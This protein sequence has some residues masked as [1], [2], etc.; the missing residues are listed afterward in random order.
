MSATYLWLVIIGMH[1]VCHRSK[2]ELSGIDDLFNIPVG[3]ST[4]LLL[5]MSLVGQL[6]IL[7][8]YPSH[9]EPLLEE[10]TTPEQVVTGWVSHIG[11]VGEEL[12]CCYS[13]VGVD[14][15]SCHVPALC[16]MGEEE[17]EV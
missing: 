4:E 11:V 15:G 3:V 17:R 9:A 8:G 12:S 1:A 6:L 7:R 2:R 16:S 10:P 13:S 5:M 14:M